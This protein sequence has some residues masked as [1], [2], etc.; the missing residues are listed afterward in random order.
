MM[1]R[2]LAG[3]IFVGIAILFLCAIGIAQT[4][5]SFISALKDTRFNDVVEDWTSPDLANSH[6]K[7]A[8][9]LIGFVD[10]QSG[11]SV[12]LI[13]LQWR[14]GD[15][16]DLWL[17]KPSGVKKPPVILYLYGYPSETDI[18][19]DPKWQQFTTSG[20][21]ASVGF[22]TALTGHRYHDIPWEKWFVSELQECMAVSA[23]DVHMVLDYLASRGDV[24]MDRVGMF[25][26]LSGASVGILASAVD[27]RI[28]VLDTFD[29]WGDWPN[30][31][32]KSPFVPEGERPN[33]VKAE[34]LSQVASLEPVNWMPKIQAKK[35]RLQQRGFEYETPLASKEKLQAAVPWQAVVVTYKT[36]AEFTEGTGKKGIKSLDWIKGELKAL[37]PRDNRVTANKSN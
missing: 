18:F 14:R 13:R 35:F 34:F 3:S 32:A 12:S 31:M 1:L 6:L 20:G 28:K 11:Y 7:P 10:E 33:Y 15:P 22:V 27:P 25:A 17:M 23:H 4:E 37:M 5:P 36:P 8:Q 9:P 16:I 2:N 26:Q 19:K 30:W 24:D 29:P 21:F